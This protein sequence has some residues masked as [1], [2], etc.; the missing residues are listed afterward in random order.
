MTSPEIQAD[1]RTSNRDAAPFPE[2]LGWDSHETGVVVID[3]AT[4]GAMQD[5][6]P[7]A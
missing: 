3:L 6:A 2:S 4:S 7:T 5:N 1:S